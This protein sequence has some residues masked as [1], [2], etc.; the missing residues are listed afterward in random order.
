MTAVAWTAIGLL[1]LL[2]LVVAWALSF[3][4]RSLDRFD[5]TMNAALD[6]FSERIGATLDRLGKESGSLYNR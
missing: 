6:R 1:A 3:L 5:R 2:V 4:N